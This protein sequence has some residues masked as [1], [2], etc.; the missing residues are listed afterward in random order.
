MRPKSDLI[1]GCAIIVAVFAATWAAVGFRL[2]CL[3][4]LFT[5]TGFTLLPLLLRRNARLAATGVAAFQWSTL[6]LLL[7]PRRNREQLRELR[8]REA[9]RSID[10]EARR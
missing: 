4:W 3:I 10:T 7:R 6:L 8:E 2:A 5:A 9:N 1:I